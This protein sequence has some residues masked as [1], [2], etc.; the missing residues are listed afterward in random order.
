MSSITPVR[1]PRRHVRRIRSIR[2]AHTTAPRRRERRAISH[3]P[4]PPSR[5]S[6]QSLRLAALVF[7]QYA[8]LALD[9]R[10]IASANYLGIAVVNVA[11]ATTTWYVTKDIVMARSV[12]DRVCFAVGGT[13]GALLA[14]FA[15]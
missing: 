8:L 10:F 2:I 3:D 5:S 1:G 9:M 4:P 14:V 11:I 7:V 6:R 13:A 12:T 15:T